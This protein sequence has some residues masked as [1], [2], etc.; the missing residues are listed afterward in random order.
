MLVYRVLRILASSK[1]PQSI[2]RRRTPHLWGGSVTGVRSAAQASD[3]C[4]GNFMYQILKEL[5]FGHIVHAGCLVLPH[6]KRGCYNWWSG[7]NQEGH[8]SLLR[9]DTPEGWDIDEDVSHRIK[10]DWLKW[11]QASSVLCDPRVSLKLK[12][13][14]YRTTIRPTMLYE[15]ECWPTKRQHVQ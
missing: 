7:G 11:R 6:M 15:V 3:N 8:L 13:K 4:H 1:I 12:G 9:I 10:C 14:F 2:L 5:N